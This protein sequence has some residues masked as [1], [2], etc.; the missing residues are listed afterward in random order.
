[1]KKT[2]FFFFVFFTTLLAVHSGIAIAQE[3][4]PSIRDDYDVTFKGRFFYG[5]GLGMQ[6]GTV[7]MVDVAPQFGYYPLENIAIG[8]GLTY[9]YISDRRYEPPESLHVLGTSIFTNLHLPFYN[10][11]FAHGEYEFIAYNTDVFSLDNKRKWICV[12]N[13]LAGIGYRQRIFNRSSIFLMVLWN[14]NETQYNLYSN[15]VIRMG[16]N[17]GF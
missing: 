14:F 11:I 1:M 15:P 13:V 4:E 5:G 2:I 16:V 10:S 7:T 17:F 6:F 8:M 9:Q 3:S 12:H